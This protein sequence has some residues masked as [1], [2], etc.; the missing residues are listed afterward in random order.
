MSVIMFSI[1]NQHCLLIDKEKIFSKLATKIFGA[2][3]HPINVLV[4]LGGAVIELEIQ[5]TSSTRLILVESEQRNHSIFKMRE[6]K[7][8]LSCRVEIGF[9]QLFGCYQRNSSINS[10]GNVSSEE[11]FE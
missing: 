11:Y 6:L 2:L 1:L 3:N 5:L 9:G 10:T 8:M 7:S 4:M